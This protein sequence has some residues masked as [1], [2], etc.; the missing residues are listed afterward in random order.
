MALVLLNAGAYTNTKDAQ[1][2]TP[3][4]LVSQYR[5]LGPDYSQGDGVGI[6][7]LLLNHGADVNMQ[8]N[9]HATQIWRHITGEQR[10]QPCYSNTVAKPTRRS[11]SARPHVSQSQLVS[12]GMVHQVRLVLVLLGVRDSKEPGQPYGYLADRSIAAS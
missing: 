7:Q 5:H 6:A 10:S 4:H 3:L 1:G 12:T 2:Q 9:N 8:D 11:T